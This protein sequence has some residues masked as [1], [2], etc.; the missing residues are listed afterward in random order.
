MRSTAQIPKTTQLSSIVKS[1]GRERRTGLNHRLSQAIGR[2]VTQLASYRTADN[3]ETSSVRSTPTDQAYTLNEIS[4]FPIEKLD[5]HGQPA[6]SAQQRAGNGVQITWQ[7]EIDGTIKQH[8]L[9]TLR[10]Q[11]N[12]KGS[13]LPEEIKTSWGNRLGQNLSRFQ[14]H[15]NSESGAAVRAL[16]ANAIN[17][18]SHLFFAPG[19]YNPTSSHGRMLLGHEITHGLQTTPSSE[20]LSDS[21]DTRIDNNP[22]LEQEAGHAGHKL[23]HSDNHAVHL[24]HAGQAPLALRGDKKITFSGDNVT[25]RDTYV[26]HGPGVTDEFVDRFR[27]ALNTYYNA[28]NFVYRDYNVKFALSVRRARYKTVLQSL[29]SDPI[30]AKFMPMQEQQVMADSPTDSDTKLFHVVKGEGRAGGIGEITLYE[31]SGEGTIAHEVGHYLSDRIGYFSEGYTEGF[32]SRLN[33]GAP[34]T[35]VRPEAVGDIMASSSTGKVSTFSLSGILDE[36][37]DEHETV[38][39]EYKR[40]GDDIP[41]KYSPGYF[42]YGEPKI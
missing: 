25:V 35:S 14:V 3:R 37:I 19:A 24:T 21:T 22:L 7:R 11:T 26:V 36:A 13:D 41:F 33:I 38:K 6:S 40:P 34:D 10:R 28:P 8:P 27:N 30:E 5:H 39:E 42:P 31:T 29:A 20:A 2:N 23:M 16:G 17:F 32:L 12:S 15:D 4:I 1:T 18:G 9:T